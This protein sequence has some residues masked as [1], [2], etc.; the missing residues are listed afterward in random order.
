MHADPASTASD[1]IHVTGVATLDGTVE[2]IGPNGNYAPRTTYN[3]LTADGGVQGRFTGASSTYAF[4]TPTLSYDPKNVYMTLTRNDVPIGSIGGTGNESSVGGALD[5]QD[6]PATGSGSSSTGNGL[7]GV[8]IGNGGGNG[9]N[10]STQA[11]GASR[12]ASG[13]DHDPGPGAHGAEAAVRRSLPQ[14]RQRVLSQGD[15]VRTLSLDRLRGNRRAHARRTPDGPDRRRASPDALPQSGA[16]PVWTQVVG[17]WSKF[18]RRQRGQREPVVRR[19]LR[20]RRHRS[21]QRLAR[22]R[23]GGLS[24]QP[25]HDLRQRVAHQGRQLHGDRLRRPQL[26][27]RPGQLRFMAGAAHWHNIDAKRDVAAGTLNQQL[28]SSYRATSTQLYTELGYCRW[29][30]PTASNPTPAWNQLHAR[31]RSRRQRR[32]E[33]IGQHHDVASSTLACAAHGSLAPSAATA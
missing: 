15:T 25:Q 5:K 23:R 10:T 33:R 11:S 24:G 9:G 14:Q 6:P 22:G 30:M 7:S 17:N 1:R 21:R 31:L 13:P 18:G 28:K 3:I 2:H 4:L 8:G 19:T 29:A 12:H 32:A 16:Y 27:R 20:R 26:R